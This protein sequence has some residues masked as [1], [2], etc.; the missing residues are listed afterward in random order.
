[1]QGKKTLNLVQNERVIQKR[2]VINNKNG[3]VTKMTEW[4]ESRR[5][6]I[7]LCNSVITDTWDQELYISQL[8]CDTNVC[9]WL[10][11][12][13]CAAACESYHCTGCQHCRQTTGNQSHICCCSRPTWWPR[14]AESSALV[15]AP[16]LQPITTHFNFLCTTTQLQIDAMTHTHTPV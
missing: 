13:L 2:A 16:S 1:M 9:V 7:Q 8:V 14:A 5:F 12:H 6:G 3:L 11:C 4:R 10:T 15:S